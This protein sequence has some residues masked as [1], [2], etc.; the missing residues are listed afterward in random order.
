[1]ALITTVGGATSDSYATVAEAD[2]YAEA[3]GFTDWLDLDDEEEKEPALR[4]GT[5]YMD[6]KFRGSIKGRK[7]EAT[8]ALAFPR[9]G[10]SDEDGNEFDDDVIPAPW[11]NASMEA[12]FRESA[13]AGTLFP[14]V[15]RRTSSEKVGP[16]S[17]SYEAG[18]EVKTDLTVIDNLVSG[19]LVTGGSATFGFLARA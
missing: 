3:H 4:K 11:K 14:D 2:T 16:I 9:T 15:E 8:Q 6:G 19:L 13:N 10:C 7:T 12:A 1:M 17:V 18:A 5:Q